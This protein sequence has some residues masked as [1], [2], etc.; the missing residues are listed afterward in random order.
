MPQHVMTLALDDCAICD[1]PEAL[2]Y[3]VFNDDGTLR[4]PLAMC[5]TCRAA[6]G[7][8]RFELTTA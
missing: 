7:A 8:G 3:D 2:V 1:A 4:G 5:P 6:I